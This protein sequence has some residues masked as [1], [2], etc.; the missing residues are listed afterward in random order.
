MQQ[1]KSILVVTSILFKMCHFENIT[2]IFLFKQENLGERLD[3]LCFLEP[4]L[5]VISVT[6]PSATDV[7]L[8][9]AEWC[10]P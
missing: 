2:V 7:D 6:R 8:G 10:S 3:S 5:S 9:R 1:N 4:D